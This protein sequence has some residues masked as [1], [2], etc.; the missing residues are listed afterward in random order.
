MPYGGR[1][2]AFPPYRTI[3]TSLKTNIS[4]RTCSE[5]EKGD[6]KSTRNDASPSC[7]YGISVVEEV[8]VGLVHDAYF[9][10]GVA[11]ICG[12]GK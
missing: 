9:L 3:A 12:L 11:Q 8:D 10:H 1:R 4:K 2:Y 5:S 6:E 7:S